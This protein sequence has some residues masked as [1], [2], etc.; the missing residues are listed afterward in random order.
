MTA[1]RL[2]VLVVNGHEVMSELIGLLRQEPRVGRVDFAVNA[3]HA[4]RVSQD[5]LR[6][7]RQVHAWFHAL[8]PS[9]PNTLRLAL[10]ARCL[11][12][13]P[14]V[15]VVTGRYADA[16]TAL[17]LHAAD[18]LITPLTQRRLAATIDRL[19]R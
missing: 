8:E 11:G 10:T 16:F 6:S 15:V 14:R 18:Y 2:N 3:S 17:E 4:L 19:G 12:T 13:P 7:Q 1:T 5:A 9:R